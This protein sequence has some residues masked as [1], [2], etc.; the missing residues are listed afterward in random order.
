[1]RTSIVAFAIVIVVV[2]S[3]TS[4]AHASSIDRELLRRV[5]VTASPA[6]AECGLPVERYAVRLVVE[7][8]GRISDVRVSEPLDVSDEHARCV[9]RAF[10]RVTFPAF[11]PPRPASRAPRRGEPRSHLP[12]AARRVGPIVIHWPFVVRG[13]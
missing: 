13:G 5:L 3:W 1:V 7:G 11:E 9:V 6:L 4:R 8:D 12:P 2:A 10:E